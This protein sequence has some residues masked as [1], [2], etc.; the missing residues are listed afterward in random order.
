MTEVTHLTNKELR[1]NLISLGFQAGSALTLF[2]LLHV[3]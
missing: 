1:D 3:N 2:S